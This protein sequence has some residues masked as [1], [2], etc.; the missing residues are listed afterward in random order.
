MH[1]LADTTLPPRSASQFDSLAP[2][3]ADPLLALIAMHDADGRAGKL[4]LGVGV[5]RNEA[6]STPVMAS[7][8]T[9][10]ERLFRDQTS[11]AY[12]GPEGDI[13]F[14]DLVR[15][16]V[17]G[18]RTDH[19]DRMIAVQTP[20][21]SGALRLGAELLSR[22]AQV[23]RIW[24]GSPTWPNHVPV[25]R[26]AG[27]HVQTHPFYDAER[28]D[29]DFE[30]M[31]AAVRTIPRGDAL[32]VHGCCHNPTGARFSRE[33]WEALVQEVA[34]RGILP[35]V[36]LAYQGLGD[37]LEEDAEGVR[38]M[39]GAVPEALVAYSCSKNFGM[40]RD[41]VGALWVTAANPAAATLAWQNVM[42]LA[43]TLWSMPPDHGAAV[44][45]LLLEDADLTAQWKGELETMRLRLNRLRAR[46]S[47]QHHRLKAIG[48]QRGMFALLPIDR[49]AVAELRERHGIYMADSGR[50]N[51]AGLHEAAIAPFAD[52]LR[53]YLGD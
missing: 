23:Q 49:T 20:G 40:Y 4:D 5:Y 48:G 1:T 47:E 42:T 31:M 13:R 14:T 34:S 12:L 22:T 7:V 45:R 26:E 36:D 19:A 3:P 28:G 29:L 18:N 43:R 24:V 38:R 44:I 10:E 46:L 41:R 17:F 11:K 52:M 35:F 51:I 16:L 9:S 15:P 21:G 6:G 30:A 32:L 8:K 27:L 53:P 33:Q 25:F 50:M 37:G 39:V 2:Q